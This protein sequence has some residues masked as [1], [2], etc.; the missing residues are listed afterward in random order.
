MPGKPLIASISK[1]EHN[2]KGP[3]VGRAS[4]EILKKIAF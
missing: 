3:S 2:K 4:R 1:P